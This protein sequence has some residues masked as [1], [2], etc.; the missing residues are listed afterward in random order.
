MTEQKAIGKG[1]VNKAK[2][3]IDCRYATTHQ[4]GST[5]WISCKFQ[6]GW[7]SINSE[8]NLPNKERLK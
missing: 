2:Y 3:C 4:T 7:R 5:I 6:S 1:R 8:C